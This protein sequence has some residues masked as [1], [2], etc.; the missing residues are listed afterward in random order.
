MT[1]NLEKLEINA[2]ALVSAAMKAGADKCDVVVANGNSLGIGVREGKVENTGRAEGDEFSLRV[3]VGK[4]TASVSANQP[5]DFAMLAERAVAMARV[6]PEDPFQDLV[7]EDELAKNWPDLDTLD[8]HIPDADELTARALEAENAALSVDGVSKSM[9]AS[10]GWGTSGFVL[11]T[12]NGFAGNYSVSRF[13]S[14]ASALCGEGEAMERDYDM[15]AVTHIGDLRDPAEIGRTAGE[16]AVRR[17]NPKTVKSGSYPLVFDRRIAGGM[18]GALLGAINASSVARKTSFLRNSMGKAVANPAVTVHDDP[19]RI[20]GLG[21]RPFD[22]EGLA[23]ARRAI[24]ENGMLTGWTLDLSSARKL[25][26]APT[27]NAARGVSSPPS[28]A[29]WNIELVGNGQRRADLIKGI[30]SGLLV[31]SMIGS[32]INPNTGDYSRGAS[33]FWIENGEIAWPVN[34]CT[35]AGNLHDMLRRMVPADDAR[36]WL[37]RVAPSILIEGMTL[38]GQ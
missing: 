3:F 38:A 34:E 12:S 4:R 21:S 7:A 2:R 23:T 13:S 14:S 15:H 9:G 37:S 26:L 6:S 18:L 27:G 22:G 16:R 1:I 20:R 35:I 30:G 33:G 28:P 32:T 17:S 10:A 8:N 25:D 36:P 31:T 5:G 29:N 11:A 19:H 24:V